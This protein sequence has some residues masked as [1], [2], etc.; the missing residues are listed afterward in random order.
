MLNHLQDI[1]GPSGELCQLILNTTL[2][3]CCSPSMALTRIV[4]DAPRTSRT[5]CP[6][7][8]SRT[9]PLQSLHAP[10]SYSQL[11]PVLVG[12]PSYL[13]LSNFS[14]SHP[15]P[16]ASYC[17][18]ALCLLPSGVHPELSGNCWGGR[19]QEGHLPSRASSSSTTWTRPGCL[20]PRG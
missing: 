12:S 7:G 6:P 16:S 8:S 18:P 9:R 11:P 3:R 1:P 4:G 10:F 15:L 13:S 5:L 19:R 2:S 14:K 17:S 20:T